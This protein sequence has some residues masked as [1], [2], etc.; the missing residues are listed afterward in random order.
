MGELTLK[1]KYRINKIPGQ[2]PGQEQSDSTNTAGLGIS[3]T[4]T[5]FL[6]IF[7]ALFTSWNKTGKVGSTVLSKGKNAFTI[8]QGFYFSE[9]NI[10]F[11]MA[12]LFAVLG[13]VMLSRK[14]FIQ[15]EWR[16][17]AL[18]STFILLPLI[19]ILFTYYGPNCDIHYVLASSIFIG[20]TIIQFIIL[21]LYNEYYENEPVLETYKSLVDTMII[22]AILIVLNFA[23]TLYI[24]Y[25]KNKI[26]K[27]VSWLLSDFLAIS[28]YTHLIVYGILL[29][30][31]STF[32]GLPDL[33]SPRSSD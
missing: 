6:I 14:N 13:I 20:G 1:R 33:D 9:K 7:Y 21:S 5:Y 24:K 30:M 11:L 31:F 32:A 8:S 2:I 18:V 29:Y 12:I 15:M 3:V 17:I 26:P 22:F 23:A 27:Q 28:E 19:M 4:L 10:T 25:N 16:R